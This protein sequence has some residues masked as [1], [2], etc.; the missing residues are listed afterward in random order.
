MGGGIFVLPGPS[1]SGARAQAVHFASDYAVDEA[2]ATISWAA[3]LWQVTAAVEGASIRGGL[4]GNAWVRGSTLCTSG[5]SGAF[6]ANL[7][8]PS[9]PRIVVFGGKAAMQTF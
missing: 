1:P 6:R 4:R 9:P 2:F 3:A 5:R 7:R 8:C